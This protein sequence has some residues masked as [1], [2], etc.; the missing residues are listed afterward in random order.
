M[1]TTTA[2]LALAI[3]ESPL[4]STTATETAARHAFQRAAALYPQE[5][6]CI[7]EF[8]GPFEA[9]GWLRLAIL[10]AEEIEDRLPDE[11]PEFE[12][13]LFGDY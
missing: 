8:I 1:T 4:F 3:I 12:T 6:A 5:A 11:C 9:L 7:N 10:E 13:G 2:T